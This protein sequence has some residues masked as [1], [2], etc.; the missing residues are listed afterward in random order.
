MYGINNSGTL[1]ELI[2]NVHG[3]HNTTSLRERTFAGKLNQ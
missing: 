1:A 2:E 3:M